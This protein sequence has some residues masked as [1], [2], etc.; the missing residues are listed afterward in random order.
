VWNSTFDRALS[1]AILAEKVPGGIRRALALYASRR[2]AGAPRTQEEREIRDALSRLFADPIGCEEEVASL[3]A[4]AMTSI[5]DSRQSAKTKRLDPN[6]PDQASRASRAALAKNTM[7][8][9]TTS[10][11]RRSRP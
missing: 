7:T 3:L 6:Q 2:T 10:R 1:R 8:T 4:R 5:T 11:Q 9:G